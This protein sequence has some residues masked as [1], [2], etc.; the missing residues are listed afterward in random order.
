MLHP[1]TKR[2]I[3]KLDEMTRKQRVS[4]EESE[5]DAVTHDTEG[6]RVALTAAP[7]TLYL[8]DALGREIETCTPEDFAGETDSSGRPYADF[9]AELYREAHRHARGAEKA[10]SALLDSL[11]RVEEPEEAP[12]EP[13]KP[14]V[15]M[16][17]AE[18][19]EHAEDQGDES[20]P[21]HDDELPEL[22]GEADMQK[23]VAAMA[24]ELNGGEAEETGAP[25]PAAAPA[26]EAPAPVMQAPAAPQPAAEAASTYAPFAGSAAETGAYVAAAVFESP[27]PAETVTEPPAETPATPAT[28]NT[29]PEHDAVWEAIQNAGTP[30]ASEAAQPAEPEPAPEPAPPETTQETVQ[31]TAEAPARPAPVFGGGFFGGTGDLSR[32]RSTAPAAPETASPQ[33]LSEPPAP[34][35]EPAAEAMPQAQPAPEPEAPAE[36]EPEP[37]QHF[38]LSGITS[39]FGLGATHTATR[40]PAAEP[41]ATPEPPTPAE[42]SARKVIDGTIDLPDALP[43]EGQ[44]ESP[45]AGY[46]MEEDADF[47]FTA[48]DMMPGVEASPVPARPI[49]SGVPATPAVEPSAHDTDPTDPDG[50]H[51]PRP[52]R[53]FNPWN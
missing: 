3:D 8:T 23:A 39:G 53:R 44:E 15:A 46:R 6:Y 21:L 49:P 40:S 24:D 12:A 16:P 28:D 4:W 36:P 32:Y 31:E 38:S 43:E 35:P 48:T 11:D 19:F 30:P 26:E 5:N 7:H 29:F 17:E 25:E 50:D 34:A 2:L 33:S 18:T 51:T 27:A 47:D 45:D 52:S 20:M 42:P 9:V 41:E 10:I 37:K 14:V 13:A 1:S 22:E